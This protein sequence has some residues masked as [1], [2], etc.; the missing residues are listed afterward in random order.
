MCKTNLPAL[1]RLKEQLG[2]EGFDIV[3]LPVDPDD[4]NRKLGDYAKAWKPASRLV[5]IP[6]GKRME[7]SVAFSKALGQ[8]APV[9]STVVVDATGHIL[10]AEAGVP[11]VSELRRIAPAAVRE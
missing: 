5:I 11:S 1:R 8:D 7:T 6:P 3:F 4:D 2:P 10:L 9:P